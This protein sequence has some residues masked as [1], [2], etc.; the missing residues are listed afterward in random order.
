VEFKILGSL[1][2]RSEGR[3]LEVGAPKERALLVRLLLSPNRLVSV[4]RLV[5]DLW[6][7]PPPESVTTSL[8]VHVSRLR[9]ALG[10]E[11]R[12]ATRPS[13]YVMTVG[14]GEL[15]LGEAERL[16]AEGRALVGEGDLVGG[17]ARLSAAIELWRGPPL[18]DLGDVPFIVAEQARLAELRV[19]AI[20][21]RVEADLA[22]GRH[23]A[24]VGP[25]ESLV[26]EHP[27][28]ERLWGARML[29][30]YRCGRQADALRAYQELR[31]HLAEELGL[32]PSP[33]LARLEAAILEQHPS[34]ELSPPIGAGPLLAPAQRPPAP[35]APVGEGGLDR[36]FPVGLARL[37]T[38]PFLGR[39]HELDDLRGAWKETRGGGRRVRLIV[40]EPGIGKTRLVARLAAEA[41]DDGATVLYGR[42]DGESLVP[43][44]ALLEAIRSYVV[45]V[46][47]AVLATALAGSGGELA[48]LVPEVAERV[49]GLP[50]PVRSEPETE[51]YRLFQ[52]VVSFLEATARVSPVLLVLEN[53]HWADKP[54][55][56]LL[57]H[58]LR[59]QTEPALLV[60][61]TYCHTEL[62]SDRPLGELLG[63]LRRD[64]AVSRVQ[65]GGLGEEAAGHLIETLVDQRPDPGFVTAV[66]R[67]TEGNPLFIEEVLRHLAEARAAQDDGRRS[68]DGAALG[69]LG[70]PEGVREVIGRRLSRLSPA[71]VAALTVAS[72]LGREFDLS[73]LEAVAELTPA[74][75]LDALDEAIGG[76]V[77]VESPGRVGRYNFAHA[78][79]RETIYSGLSGIRRARWH[80]LVCDALESGAEVGRES[81]SLA[82]LAHHSFHGALGGGDVDRAIDYALLAGRQAGSM[83]GPEEAALH[84][85]RGLQLLELK[86]EPDEARSCDLLLA[87]AEAQNQSREPDAAR[88]TLRQVVAIA[89]RRGDAERLA[90]AALNPGGFGYY[91]SVGTDPEELALLEEAFASL[92]PSDS[93]LRARVMARLASVQAYTAPH[94]R[95]NRLSGDAVAMA[96]RV[97]DPAA[98]SQALFARHF[99]FWNPAAESERIAVANELIALADT[100]GDDEMRLQGH[101][102]LAQSRLELGDVAGAEA[103]IATFAEVASRTGQALFASQATM[104]Q[105]CLA[106]L[107]GR[108]EEGERLASDALSL[109]VGQTDLALSYY[110]S[111]MLW[112]WWQQGKLPVIE[113]ALAEV[114]EQAPDVFPAVRAA[115]A[116]VAAEN[117]RLDDAARELDHLCNLGLVS[118]ARD[119]S[120]PVLMTLLVP[121]VAVL[122][123]AERACELAELLEPYSGRLVV[124]G[125]PPSACY[126]PVDAYLGTLVLARGEPGEA[127]GLYEGALELVKSIGAPPF[128]A[129][130][131]GELGAALLARGRRGDAKR[132]HAALDEA[133][134]TAEE[135]GL[136]RVAARAK[137]L[138]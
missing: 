4:E 120:W 35:V 42:A 134:R 22:L 88:E 133:V 45:S 83:I 11:E 130:V 82:E 114:F 90:R 18:L 37:D 94:E 2:V 59:A 108:L 48:R 70:I 113:S 111:Q 123:D 47:P 74:E 103:E 55:L 96:R 137:A 127:V 30:L 81:L 89:R 32:V 7:A 110:G 109:G 16:V 66:H 31:R 132:A 6:P 80:R 121:V 26:A 61:A 84:Y 100:I 136:D 91:T 36:P 62:R 39:D 99:S 116:L 112:T 129:N 29:A 54:A 50:K 65:L 72:V 9:K 106:L 107:A 79:I 38:S 60:V 34:L 5:D 85:G 13:G 77:L 21:D 24:L 1:E 27:L 69:E 73:L 104:M 117:D 8:R 41:H 63:E 115:V 15:D 93:P 57:R 20:E 40:G 46:P 126:G 78:L 56:L 128:I 92:E 12:I 125:P 19:S 97:E 105:G 3:V 76:G 95:I 86:R 118:L 138:L 14:E 51:R 67:I 75:L 23:V 44:E 58:I 135:L 49:P 43:Y 119:P 52:A 64:P 10:A 71:C 101:H 87:L 68:L 17:S 102:W 122:G 98:L 53:L 28:R 33:P 25:L 131:A 124:C